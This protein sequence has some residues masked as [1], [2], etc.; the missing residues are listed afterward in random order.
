MMVSEGE[1]RDYEF[2]LL[3]IWQRAIG[4][5]R[6]TV[7]DDFFDSGG[8]SL[9][10]IQSVVEF[11]TA[12]GITIDL[13]EL[14]RSPTV[15]AVVKKIG[16]GGPSAPAILIPL[17]PHGDGIPLFCLLG[18]QVYRHLASRLGAQS[19]IFGVYVREEQAFVSGATSRKPAPVSIGRLASAYF[20]IIRKACPSGPLRL[21]G[22][23]YGG[24]VA[25]EVARRLAAGVQV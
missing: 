8:N 24:V 20:E 2:I 23:S 6:L 3:Q 12:T 9:A 10:A 16:T 7:N 4:N 14:F 13:G 15:A 22:L 17:Q 21:A 5:D 18:I 11:E 1:L 19:P 25:M